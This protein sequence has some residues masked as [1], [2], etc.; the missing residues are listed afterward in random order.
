[1]QTKEKTALNITQLRYF[2]AVCKFGSTVKAAENLFISQ[3]SVSNAIKKLEEE[4][5]LSL[6]T[7]ENNRL[8]L[9]EDGSFFLERA[10]RILNS[11]DEFSTEV[12]RHS[13]KDEIH[14]SIPPVGNM[15]VT[16]S[17]MAFR[18]SHP[19]LRIKLYEDAQ[20]EA[21][22]KLGRGRR[23]FVLTILDDMNA[24]AS[25]KLETIPLGTVSLKLCVSCDSP[26]A[27]LEQ[28]AIDQLGNHPLVMM[29]DNYYQNMLL[30]NRFRMLGIEPN[31]ILYASLFSTLHKYVKMGYA[32]GFTYGSNTAE[33]DAVR[34]IPLVP[35]MQSTFGIICRKSSAE[36]SNV[37]EMM[38]YLKK[39]I[40]V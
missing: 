39:V 13:A 21:V 5:G 40:V 8:I 36:N 11:V 6:F 28:V 9:T 37:R 35:A 1:M 32:A 19:E 34:Y 27:A 14:L 4:Y 15:K 3:P 30:S 33:S 17:V 20:A 10:E 16:H 31:I 22:A 2:Q 38:D 18:E 12:R 23:D 7:R 24:E 25:E 26:L 29:K